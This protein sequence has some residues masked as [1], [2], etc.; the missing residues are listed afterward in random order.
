MFVK[1]LHNIYT[2]KIQSCYFQTSVKIRGQILK[3]IKAEYSRSSDLVSVFL[4]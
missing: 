2:G 4:Y 3:N 1:L